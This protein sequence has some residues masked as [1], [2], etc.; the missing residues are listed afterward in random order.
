M[1]EE[2]F[3]VAGY[4]VLAQFIC[5]DFLH[6]VEIQSGRKA[7]GRCTTSLISKHEH[8]YNVNVRVFS[9]ILLIL[10]IWTLMI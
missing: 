9:L 6:G 2:W 7:N 8:C 4:M 3:V 10:L 5:I 1:I